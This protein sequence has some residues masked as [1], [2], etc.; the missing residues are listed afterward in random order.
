MLIYENSI[1]PL[2]A[3]QPGRQAHKTTLKG[4]Q[5]SA[6]LTAAAAP[7]CLSASV[8]WFSVCLI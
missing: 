1:W 4:P 2:A 3:A 8:F 5:G 6:A 7:L